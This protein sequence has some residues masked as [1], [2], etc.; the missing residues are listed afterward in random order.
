MNGIL[1][2]ALVIA[3]LLV[4]FARLPMCR[5]SL[6][7]RLLESIE[8]RLIFRADWLVRLLGREEDFKPLRSASWDH[9]KPIDRND[10]ELLELPPP[11]LFPP[12]ADLLYIAVDFLMDWTKPFDSVSITREIADSKLDINALMV[13]PSNL[14]GVRGSVFYDDL[15]RILDLHEA[16]AGR[17]TPL[18]WRG[19]CRLVGRRPRWYV[20][21][22]ARN[23]DGSITCGVAGAWTF[24]RRFRNRCGRPPCSHQETQARGRIWY[25][26]PIA[27]G[28]SS[29]KANCSGF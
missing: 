2:L 4:I 13:L 12:T 17:G 23:P 11:P 15:S 14:A 19:G 22:A 18:V 9:I 24:F 16:K 5:F 26:A 1:I 8:R 25:P 6:W 20:E 7:H 21:L 27:Q 10:K 3:A 28:H 29:Y